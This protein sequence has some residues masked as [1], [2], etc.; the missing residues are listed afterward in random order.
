MSVKSSSIST[1]RA[2]AVAQQ[3]AGNTYLVKQGDTLWSI[4]RAFGFTTLDGILAANPRIKD[5]NRIFAGQRI[6]I[7]SATNVAPTRKTDTATRDGFDTATP[8][9]AT[10]PAPVPAEVP[11]SSAPVVSAA[12]LSAQEATARESAFPLPKVLRDPAWKALTGTHATEKK[13]ALGEVGEARIAVGNRVAEADENPQRMAFTERAKQQGKDTLWLETTGGLAVKEGTAVGELGKQKL[14][15]SVGYSLTRPYL[16]DAGKKD[17]AGV[18]KTLAHHNSVGLPLTAEKAR[19]MEPGSTFTLNG[20]LAGEATVTSERGSA[21]ATAS[22]TQQ[23]SM[24]FM[25]GDKVMV[26]VERGAERGANGNVQG[27]N[28]RGVSGE[29]GARAATS[30]ETTERFLL[31]LS[32]PEGRKAYDR[33]VTFDGSAARGA[34]SRTDSGVERTVER[35]RVTREVGANARTTVA[36]SEST[37]LTANVSASGRTTAD[38]VTGARTRSGEIA[39]NVD[40]QTRIDEK[41]TLG[42][43]PSASRSFSLSL[44]DGTGDARVKTPLSAEDARTLP[45]GSTFTLRGAGSLGVKLGHDGLEAGATRSGQLAIQVERM[46]ESKVQVRADVTATTRLDRGAERTVNVGRTG[47]ELGYQGQTTVTRETTG[48]FTLDLS[49]ETH[50]KA[51]DAMMKGNVGPAREIARREGEWSTERTWNKSDQLTLS[52]TPVEWA[53]AKLELRRENVD[54]GDMRVSLDPERKAFTDAEKARGKEVRWVEQGGAIEPGVGLEHTV[55]AGPVAAKLGFNASG[56]LEYREMRPQVNGALTGPRGPALSADAALAM[57]RG[58]EFSLRGRGTVGGTVGIAKGAEVATTG[59]RVGASVSLAHEREHARELE[60]HSKRLDGTRVEVEL[61][62]RKEDSNA[63]DFTARLGVDVE[64]ARLIGAKDGSALAKVAG[65]ADTK[66]EKH[67]SAEFQAGR[68]STRSVENRHSFTIDLA[69]PEGRKAYESLMRGDPT[70]AA[71]VA[72]S[73][74]A[75]DKGVAFNSTSETQATEKRNH[76]HL[77]VGGSK[78]FLSDALRRDS[79]TIERTGAGMERTDASLYERTRQGLFSKQNLTMEAVRVRTTE[80]PE[81]KGFYRVSYANTDKLTSKSQVKELLRL[82]EA[83]QAIPAHLPKVEKDGSRNLSRLLGNASRHGKTTTEMEIFLTEKG[84]ANVRGHDR[85]AALRAYG[86]YAAKD[87]KGKTPA[88]AAPETADKA[89]RILDSYLEEKR[90]GMPGDEDSRNRMD[91][92]QYE[93]WHAFRRN[94]WQDED[95]YEN[96]RHFANATQRMAGSSDPAEW[97]R[98]FAD[99]GKNVGLDFHGSVAALNK[100]A[101]SDEV[102]VHRFN[103]KGKSVDIEMKDEGLLDRPQ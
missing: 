33:L 23:T 7:P 31:D 56:L 74:G 1:Q 15:G 55:T 70:P 51:Y 76:V 21:T 91:Q 54:P 65:K 4:A 66:L 85:E 32:K 5:A 17:V 22:N 86:E 101:G 11:V 59:V 39:A 67:L 82:G 13:V 25:G 9:V 49:Q 27:D 50:R 19:A 41:T 60:V 45:V 43:T 103:V 77:A 94:I 20:K 75:Q 52:T 8:P 57:P 34:A 28:G 63:T 69:T 53:K 26:T 92:L 87:N 100:L 6:N 73:V 93:Y 95:H 3:D 40:L 90:N 79:T 88:W 68:R 99:L 84:L 81:G 2:G 18:A 37:Q 64:T 78:L 46:S 16:V 83:L 14:E 96:A 62:Q 71:T 10:R 58:A 24:R 97:N 42:L 98:A 48:N 36:T 102:L 29:V 35:N 89:R 12:T 61:I 38:H 80:D 47:V 44:P 30:R 72:G